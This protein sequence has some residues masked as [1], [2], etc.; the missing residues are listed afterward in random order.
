MLIALALAISAAPVQSAVVPSSRSE[1][2]WV[3][4]NPDVGGS[5][6]DGQRS[7]LQRFSA[8]LEQN[9]AAACRPAEPMVFM[10]GLP[11]TRF[12][13][14]DGVGA[15]FLLPARSLPTPPTPRSDQPPPE[16]SVSRASHGPQVV[17][18]QRPSDL[19]DLEARIRETRKEAERMRAQADAAFADAE[20][21]LMEELRPGLSESTGTANFPVPWTLFLQDAVED[22]RTRDEVEEDVKDAIVAT[23]LEN[24]NLLK[25]LQSRDMITASVDL[26][27]RPQPWVRALPARTVVVRA[28][29]SDLD[30]FVAGKLP[31]DELLKRVLRK[32][33]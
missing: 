4:A 10:S 22:S 28:Q 27:S 5:G 14:L 19:A 24:S 12:V 26:V 30:A 16:L 15:I 1:A 29:K 17:L 31:K 8:R 25:S 6:Q 11:E 2:E 9:L 7:E 33:Y 18:I 21:Q 13:Y 20:R 32:A 23:I 3:Q